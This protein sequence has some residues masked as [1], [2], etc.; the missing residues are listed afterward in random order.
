MCV[1]SGG[2]DSALRVKKEWVIMTRLW[3][4]ESLRRSHRLQAESREHQ[5]LELRRTFL[6]RNQKRNNKEIG[7]ESLLS[8]KPGEEHIQG[9]GSLCPMRLRNQ[10][11]LEL[12]SAH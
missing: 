12:Q 2:R 8:E 11:Q 1:G 5:R 10:V 4:R 6:Q 3:V 9:V 7:E